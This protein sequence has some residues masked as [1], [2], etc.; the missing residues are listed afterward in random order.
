MTTAPAPFSATLACRTCRRD[1]VAV[2]SGRAVPG[3]TPNI[4]P[5]VCPYCHQ[6]RRYMLPGHLGPPI[7]SVHTV[8][9]WKDGAPHRA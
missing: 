6:L 1:F 2:G 8:E 4:E 9:D 3:A 7:V 5:V